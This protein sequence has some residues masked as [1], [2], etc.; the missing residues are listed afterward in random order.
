MESDLGFHQ[1]GGGVEALFAKTRLVGGGIGGVAPAFWRGATPAVERFAQHEGCRLGVARPQ[2]VATASCGVGVGVVRR[3]RSDAYRR[4]R[5]RRSD[6]SRPASGPR[7]RCRPDRAAAATRV[8]AGRSLDRAA[9]PH[10]T[11]PRQGW[12]VKPGAG[13]RLR[14][15][16]ADPATGHRKGRR[17][18]RHRVHRR[19]RRGV[20]ADRSAPVHYPSRERPAR[21]DD[22][23]SVVVLRAFLRALSING[24][25]AIVTEPG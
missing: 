13:R 24:P 5:A 10:P 3:R 11:A 18:V 2:R 9:V 23:G 22:F 17:T 16:S 8:T 14:G 12:L 20:R 15:G 19:G 25:R 21:G 6:G 4:R 1:V 7:G